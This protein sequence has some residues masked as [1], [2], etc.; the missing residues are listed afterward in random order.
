MAESA[1]TLN[2]SDEHYAAALAN[3]LTDKMG[4]TKL[5][6]GNL[7]WLGW[8]FVFINENKTPIGPWKKRDKYGNVTDKIPVVGGDAKIADHLL[9]NHNHRLAVVPAPAGVLLID[10]D[11]IHKKRKFMEMVFALPK[12][13]YVRFNSSTKEKWHIYIKVKDKGIFNDY[14]IER[15]GNKLLRRR[16]IDNPVFTGDAIGL[17]YAKLHDPENIRQ[18]Q[19]LAKRKEKCPTKLIKPFLKGLK[20]PSRFFGDFEYPEPSKTNSTWAVLTLQPWP[21]KGARTD[22]LYKMGFK[23]GANNS[24]NLLD[25]ARK[26]A[27]FHGYPQDYSEEKMDTELWNGWRDGQAHR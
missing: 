23:A 18:L 10:V 3:I 9:G 27:V 21:S 2:R 22:W 4:N 24:R 1:F 12:D 8:G 20:E 25:Q 13:S 16:T 11:T 6:A 17:H 26:V 5:I 14:G 15:N 7:E 19:R